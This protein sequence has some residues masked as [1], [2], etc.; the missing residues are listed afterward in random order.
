MIRT[1]RSAV[2]TPSAARATWNQ[3]PCG[4]MIRIRTVAERNRSLANLNRLAVQLADRGPQII[5]DFLSTANELRQTS[6]A[7]RSILSSDNAERVDAVIT[8]VVTTSE[9]IS[10]LSIEARQYLQALAGPEVAEQVQQV[11]TNTDS[12]ARELNAMMGQTRDQLGR[13]LTDDYGLAVVDAD[14]IA[15]EVVVPGG[16]CLDEI[17]MRFGP[18]VLLDD[19]SLNRAVLR[20]RIMAD[21]DERKALEA[22]THPAIF[23]AMRARLATLASDGRRFA[24]VEAALMVETGS[25]RLYPELIVV[26]CA[27]EV[28]IRRVMAR[29]GIDEVQAR[30]TLA[31]QLPLREKEAVATHVIRNAQGCSR[32]RRRR[33][34]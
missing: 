32:R 20:A 21:P 23:A 4:N 29:D 28:Q 11:L 12:A 22:I 7:L 3:Y 5:D 24:V 25:Y 8:N 6:E 1:A 31:A 18:E 30:Q 14:Q 9:N 17:A 19:G 10:E 33:R 15:R 26:S 27:P 2:E 13:I 16:P 34:R